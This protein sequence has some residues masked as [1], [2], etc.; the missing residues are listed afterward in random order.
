MSVHVFERI[1]DFFKLLSIPGLYFIKLIESSGPSTQVL[2]GLGF[3]S[4]SSETG[5]LFP[6]EC[7][8]RASNAVEVH[9]QDTMSICGFDV[10]EYKIKCFGC[11]PFILHFYR[12]LIII[13]FK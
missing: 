13:E 5:Q 9:N 3:E 12:T 8:I 4:C 1:Q 11:I 6:I 2:A 7:R 10:A